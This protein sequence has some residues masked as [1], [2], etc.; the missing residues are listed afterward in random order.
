MISMV[1]LVLAPT[2]QITKWTTGSSHEPIGR[3]SNSS[4]RNTEPGI[5]TMRLN[6]MN[7]VQ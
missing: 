7:T 1:R 2:L 3:L 6:G 4:G 5:V